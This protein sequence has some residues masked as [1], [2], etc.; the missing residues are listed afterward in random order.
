MKFQ[1]EVNKG[2]DK[3]QPMALSNDYLELLREVGHICDLLRGDILSLQATL[4]E[5]IRM[6]NGDE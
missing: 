5:V 6:G 3:S 4:Q 2:A 1:D